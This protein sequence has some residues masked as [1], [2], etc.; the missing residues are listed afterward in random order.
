MT[1]FSMQSRRLYPTDPADGASGAMASATP[2]LRAAPPRGGG[3]GSVKSGFTLVE[4]MVAL[5]VMAMVVTVSFSG[6]T[7][8][9]NSWDRGTKAIDNLDRRMTVERLL[10][11]Q[12]ALAYPTPFKV[13][14]RSFVLFRGTRHRLEFISDYSLS[15]G[16]GDFRKI[17][18]AT[19]GG[20]FLYGEKTLFDYIPA[21]NEEPP[22]ELLASFKEVSFR[23]LGR[24][25]DGN[26][27]WLEEWA[28]GMGL[29]AAVLARI[30]DDNFIIRLVNRP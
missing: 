17:D 5:A 1:I 2:A 28:I 6:L 19:E 3:E 24:G 4:V 15:D 18:Y 13:D 10:K 29:P 12:L 9:L 7:V 21:E 26:A 27:A 23:Y 11:R 22:T 8:G 20:R 14:D 30:D 25:D 16:P